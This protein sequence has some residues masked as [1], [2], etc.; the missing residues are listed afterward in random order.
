MLPNVKKKMSKIHPKMLHEIC[1]VI[2]SFRINQFLI[3]IYRNRYWLEQINEKLYL[4]IYSTFIFIH[5]SLLLWIA[6]FHE[7]F[8]NYIELNTSIFKEFLFDWIESLKSERIPDLW[9]IFTKKPTKMKDHYQWSNKLEC[10][11][12]FPH[13]ILHIY[14]EFGQ[15]LHRFR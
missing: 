7:M 12:W 6:T 11:H 2:Y 3:K 15:V 8:A 4:P 9:E 10:Q 13:H 1:K 5:I 14:S